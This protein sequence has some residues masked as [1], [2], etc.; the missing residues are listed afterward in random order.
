MENFRVIELYKMRNFSGKISATFE[1]VKQNFKPLSKS[2]LFIAGPAILVSTFFFGDFYTSLVGQRG[3]ALGITEWFSSA[4]FWL[5]LIGMFVFAVLAGIFTV[6]TINNYVKAYHEK[7]STNV[8]VHEVW[9]LVRSSFWGYF[10]T[11]V[12]TIGF[13]MVAYIVSIIIIALLFQGQPVAMLVSLFG[14]IFGL[15]FL[16][17]ILVLIF[18]IRSF[19]RIGFLQA[20]GRAFSLSYG[21]WWSTFG[22][23]FITWLISYVMS[24]IFLVPIFVVQAIYS[25]HSMQ[26]FGLN[27]PIPKEILWVVQ[28]FYSISLVV[29]YLTQALPLLSATFQYFDLV[30]RREAKGLMER[31]E[32]FGAEQSAPAPSPEQYDEHY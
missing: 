12:L 30:E 25:L 6:S 29:S 21:K 4:A 1:F 24:M 9:T 26:P 22:V 15:I 8:Q 10:G 14:V 23:V 5:E 31:I 17:F 28:V 7:K 20:F 19:E 13:L 18:P 16:A 2:M 27:D 3:N 32:M 11:V